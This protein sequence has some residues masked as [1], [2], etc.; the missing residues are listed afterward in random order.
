MN[1]VRDVVAARPH[2]DLALI[3][4]VD[5]RHESEWTFGELTELS[6]YV[7]AALAD[8]G[9][10]R[11]S[12]VLTLVG[13]TID[14]ALTM[15]AC[16]RIGAAMLPCSEQLRPKDVD[17][18]ICLNPLRVLTHILHLLRDF[19]VLRLE[20]L[21]LNRQDLIADRILPGF[22]PHGYGEVGKVTVSEGQQGI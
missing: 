5:G 19:Q 12:V 3:T 6:G 16:L 10:R 21:R 17:L 22:G 20:L 4:H 1:F 9:V 2:D 18:L 11:G 7:A 8:R 13:N 15:L 14:Y